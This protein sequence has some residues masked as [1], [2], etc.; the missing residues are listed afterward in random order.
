[1]I[2]LLGLGDKDFKII[3]IKRLDNKIQKN[4]GKKDEN[5]EKFN[6]EKDLI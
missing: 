5:M 6:R 1:M 4:M 3:K 2:Q